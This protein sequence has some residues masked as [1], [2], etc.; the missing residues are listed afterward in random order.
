MAIFRLM[1]EGSV[2]WIKPASEMG[3]ASAGD[4]GS[5]LSKSTRA[6][7]LPTPRRKSCRSAKIC[8]R[9]R[10][11]RGAFYAPPCSGR[12]RARGLARLEEEV[13]GVGA[14]VVHGQEVEQVDE[15]VVEL[16]EELLRIELDR[17]VVDHAVE[18]ERAHARRAPEVPE[19]HATSTHVQL[20]QVHADRGLD[21]VRRHRGQAAAEEAL[22]SFEDRG[23]ARSI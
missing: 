8:A 23:L 10:A 5:W 4:A 11:E 13:V 9:A 3:A 21:L 20:R 7:S 14:P 22:R 12:A 1:G 18:L 2:D 15:L 19:G 6:S 16:R 17:R